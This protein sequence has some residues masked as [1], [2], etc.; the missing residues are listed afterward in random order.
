M[1]KEQL[2]NVLFDKTNFSAMV[3]RC[4]SLSILYQSTSLKNLSSS[5][6]EIWNF[7]SSLG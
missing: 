1:L 7:S 2:V 5:S 6:S 3:R 4:T